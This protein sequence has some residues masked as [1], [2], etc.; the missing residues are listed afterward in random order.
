MKEA[1][2]VA[3]GDLG[4]KDLVEMADKGEGAD[5][6]Y[7]INILRT[8]GMNVL[9]INVED[10]TTWKP[11]D[12]LPIGLQEAIKG[13][14]I[15]TRP[16]AEWGEHGRRFTL[17]QIP[18]GG[19]PVGNPI[20]GA[21]PG[22][23]RVATPERLQ[24]L[25]FDFYTKLS[26]HRQYAGG[27][28]DPLFI[29]NDIPGLAAKEES[30]IALLT[31]RAKP[32]TYGYKVDGLKEWRTYSGNAVERVD[33]QAKVEWDWFAY[34]PDQLRK[35]K[36]DPE[37]GQ[38]V[39]Q[40]GGATID[41]DNDGSGFYEA[42]PEEFV[43]AR[44]RARKRSAF[45]TQS[46]P[47]ELEDHQLFLND[48]RT[49]GYAISPDGDIQNVFNSGGPKG[50]GRL[51]LFDAIENG[52][53]T[54]DAY[55]GYLPKLYSQFGFKETGRL[56]FNRDYA[57]EGWDYERYGEPDVVFMRWGGYP[58]GREAT[59]RRL[60]VPSDWLSSKQAR[61]Y[62]DYDSAKRSQRVHARGTSDFGRGGARQ[63][64]GV[65]EESCPVYTGTGASVWR[66]L[67]EHFDRM[68]SV[69]YAYDPDQPRRPKGD[70]EGGQWTE[71]GGGGESTTGVTIKPSEERAFN[72][73]QIQTEKKLTKK[74][75]GEI[76]EKV[77]IEY[78]K[79]QGLT[80]ARPLNL[81]QQNFP[82]DLVGDHQLVEVKSGLV[83]NGKDAQKWRATIG[84]PGPNERSWLK[85]ISADEKLAWNKQKA[86]AIIER[87]HKILEE[88]SAAHGV[89]A[90][91]KT[92]TTI[93]NPDT[94]IVDVYEFDGFHSLIRWNSQQAKD[95]Y[96]GSFTYEGS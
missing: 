63:A 15:V 19:I 80:D 61:Y 31:Y 92:I 7:L 68:R 65:G 56:R 59:E 86:R 40:S 76:G 43:R 66:S 60:E 57:P 22:Y 37:G 54:L 74:E 95:A 79:N 41:D 10:F 36:G 75:T 51:A 94:R 13:R 26:F 33:V 64:G 88:F 38:W 71:G 29:F 3:R 17:D 72:G 58:G 90:R 5:R 25:R 82:V 78:M 47:S 24:D 55:D 35:P 89:P 6:P 46:P 50:A 77:V 73:E 45:L 84:Q 49:V 93:I 67:D 11:G 8:G 20:N 12:P 91:G 85:V 44:N 62:E 30:D 28:E 87:K 52:G 42:S 69:L 27:R 1:R 83:S 9:D 14:E 16:F 70:P 53:R 2:A 96:K 4:F 21:Y 34:D 81:E 23:S 32:G 48:D 18:E 39:K